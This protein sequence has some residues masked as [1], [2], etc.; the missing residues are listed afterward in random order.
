MRILWAVFG[1]V[2]SVGAFFFYCMFT[3]AAKVRE[4]LWS[5]R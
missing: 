2:A 4:E 5:K 1:T 3:K